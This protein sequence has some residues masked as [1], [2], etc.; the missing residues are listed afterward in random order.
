MGFL[1]Y[2]QQKD[3]IKYIIILICAL[4]ILDTFAMQF[5]MNFGDT[6]G[7]FFQLTEE[8]SEVISLYKI[9]AVYGCC[10]L[11]W[12]FR[13]SKFIIATCL[14]GLFAYATAAALN[15]WAFLEILK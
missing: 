7:T 4:N 1:S 3:A 14:F 8:T 2:L 13:E 15:A 10:C 11:A 9:L 6:N 5:W 12:F